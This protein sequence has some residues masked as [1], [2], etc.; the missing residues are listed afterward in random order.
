MTRARVVLA[1]VAFLAVFYAATF[2]D[3]AWLRDWEVLARGVE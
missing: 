2:V 1:I 3:S